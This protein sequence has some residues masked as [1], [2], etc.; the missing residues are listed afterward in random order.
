MVIELGYRR[1][2]DRCL[3]VDSRTFVH[4]SLHDGVLQVL[5]ILKDHSPILIEREGLLATDTTL[6]GGEFERPSPVTNRI[7]SVRKRS[8]Q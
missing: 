3:V 2:F 8:T 5:F 7:F 6:R 1:P 4:T